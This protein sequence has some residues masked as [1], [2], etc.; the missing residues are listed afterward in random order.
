MRQNVWGHWHLGSCSSVSVLWR[1]KSTCPASLFQLLLPAHQPT[2]EMDGEVLQGPVAV[3]GLAG[4]LRSFQAVWCQANPGSLGTGAAKPSSARVS[5]V[6]WK[7]LP[8]AH[9]RPRSNSAQRQ[10]FFH[11]HSQKVEGRA[12]GGLGVPKES[13]HPWSQARTTLPFG[14]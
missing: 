7:L 12:K 10:T 14:S 13:G 6:I 11:P 5:K 2:M 9:W 3:R 4:A 1:R 8:W